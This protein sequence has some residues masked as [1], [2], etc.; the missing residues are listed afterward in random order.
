MRVDSGQL[1]PDH[2]EGLSKGGCSGESHFKSPQPDHCGVHLGSSQSPGGSEL[3]V[4]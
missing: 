1:L 2:G 3:W 4:M